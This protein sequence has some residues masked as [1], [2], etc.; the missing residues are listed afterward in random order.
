LTD[1]I[2]LGASWQ[3][4][5]I[6]PPPRPRRLPT[7]WGA[8][9]VIAATLLALCGEPVDTS[10][11]LD[12]Y[13]EVAL[14]PG[15]RF[16]VTADLVVVTHDNEIRSYHLADGRPAGAAT[17]PMRLQD[18]GVRSE[19]GLIWLY[20]DHDSLD[21]E[22]IVLGPDGDLRW[23]ALGYHTP[24]A[25]QGVAV[26]VRQSAQTPDSGDDSRSAVTRNSQTTVRDLATGAIRWSVREQAAHS[27][28]A[29]RRLMLSLAPNGVYT[30]RALT[31][32]AVV[33]SATLAVQGRPVYLDARGGILSII[34][35]VA[36]PDVDTG[37]L[38]VELATLEPAPPL[39]EL[40]FDRPCGPYFCRA[41]VAGGRM[42]ETEVIAP[43]DGRVLFT[44]SPE[45]EVAPVPPG[46][47]LLSP[48]DSSYALTTAELVDPLTGQA[49]FTLK[50]WLWVRGPQSQ[51]L[52]QR[53]PD[54]EMI[55][56]GWLTETEAQPRGSLPG[57]PLPCQAS[58]DRL[59]CP[60]P[61]DRLG[62]WRVGH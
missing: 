51:V 49:R 38:A 18:T 48:P 17:V 59:V 50:P 37:V 3:H 30:E 36:T 15:A 60:R 21:G 44:V 42:T 43:D 19:A 14:P 52:A 1:I 26:S 35:E 23:T 29:D 33:R 57:G 20:N 6:E 41:Q 40:R 10:P 16:H 4:Q 58:R 61:G 56:F 31:D 5:L 53:D 55:H 54:R 28:D 8:F 24:V 39:A 34:V 7:G 12:R 13:A 47:L 11:G 9:G 27:Y 46:I 45:R 62:F 32:G 2:E 22:T 25:R